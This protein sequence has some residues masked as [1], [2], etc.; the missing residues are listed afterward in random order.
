MQERLIVLWALLQSKLLQEIVIGLL[1]LL[2]W[3]FKLLYVVLDFD[4]FPGGD[5]N[6]DHFA[7]K[8][9]I[10]ILLLFLELKLFQAVP[11]LIFDPMIVF[12]NLIQKW[13]RFF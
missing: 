13:R 12:Q 11:M 7:D 4:V 10:G 3:M 5:L 9:V 8:L 6:W 1:P 2:G